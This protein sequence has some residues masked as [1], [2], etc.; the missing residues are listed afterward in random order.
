MYSNNVWEDSYQPFIYSNANIVRGLR[1]AA[2]I[3][4]APRTDRRGSERC[5]QGE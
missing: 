1:D 3:F 5:G 4:T 2:N